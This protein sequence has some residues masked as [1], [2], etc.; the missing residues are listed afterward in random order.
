MAKAEDRSNA[1]VKAGQDQKHWYAVTLDD[2]LMPQPKNLA[3]MYFICEFFAVNGMAPKGLDNPKKMMAAW[4]YGR[5]LGFDFWGS[6]KNIAVINNR[7]TV[8]GPA[9]LGLVRRSGKLESFHEW[10]EG[11]GKTRVAYCEVKRKGDDTVY[12]GEFGMEDAELAGLLDKNSPWKGYPKDMLKYKARARALYDAFSDVLENVTMKEEAM[13]YQEAEVA[14]DEG[15]AFDDFPPPQPPKEPEKDGEVVDAEWPEFEET[16]PEPPVEPQEAKPQEAKPVTYPEVKDNFDTIFESS[17]PTDEMRRAL[18]E[19]L[20][21]CAEWF[22]MGIDVVKAEAVGQMEG[23]LKQLKQ[24]AKENPPPKEPKKNDGE[25][26]WQEEKNWLYSRGMGFKRLVD[27]HLPELAEMPDE[28]IVNSILAKWN[29]I[30]EDLGEFPLM[31]MCVK[32]ARDNQIDPKVLLTFTGN[33]KP[34]PTAPQ[35]PQEPDR[36]SIPTD[37]KALKQRLGAEL[38]YDANIVESI[39]AECGIKLTS[40][41][42]SENQE[43]LKHIYNYWG[44]DVDTIEQF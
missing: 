36:T 23:F 35:E 32:W 19:Y 2:S 41:L 5:Q 37:L 34:E 30:G 26:F 16:K 40:T 6:L 18:P 43:L 7:A 17:E 9:V 11:S 22:G 44:V 24:Y 33:T 31:P 12:K 42:V 4:I 21:Q 38:D 39:A 28:F 29:R 10:Q 20:N 25:N 3:E 13:D 27:N 8:Y 14:K 1:L 15:S